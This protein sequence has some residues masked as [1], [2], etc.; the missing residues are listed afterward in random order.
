VESRTGGVALVGSS[1]TIERVHVAEYFVEQKRCHG[2][3]YFR[4]F[5][6][7]YTG[8]RVDCSSGERVQTSGKREQRYI[9]E[10][11]LAG[12]TARLTV[13]QIKVILEDVTRSVNLILFSPLGGNRVA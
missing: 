7:E 4:G 5:T 2:Y 9:N 8:N 11:S 1:A 10:F 12:K 6:G 3:P 13:H